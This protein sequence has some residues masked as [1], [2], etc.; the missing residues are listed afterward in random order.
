MVNEIVDAHAFSRTRRAADQRRRNLKSSS[1]RFAIKTGPT[2]AS[3]CDTF[4]CV[5]ACADTVS[6]LRTMI[7]AVGQRSDVVFG[8]ALAAAGIDQCLWKPV[9]CHCL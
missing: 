5:R 8:R 9:R 3:S 7:A 6:T 1:L 2:I 4:V